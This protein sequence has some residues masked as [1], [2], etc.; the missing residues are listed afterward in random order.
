MDPTSCMGDKTLHVG[1]ETNDA[2]II[3]PTPPHLG[4]GRIRVGLGCGL[5]LIL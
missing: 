1:L 2:A 4:R 5:G 3:S